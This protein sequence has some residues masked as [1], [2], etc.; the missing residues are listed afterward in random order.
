MKRCGPT[1]V[2][3]VADAATDEASFFRAFTGFTPE[4]ADAFARHVWAT[5]NLVNL[6]EH[7]LPTRDLSDVVLVKAPD[8]A[9]RLVRVRVA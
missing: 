5:V 3:L 7:I 9:V 4:E 8:H 1:S 6:E 2:R